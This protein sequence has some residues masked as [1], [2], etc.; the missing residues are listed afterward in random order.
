MTVLTRQG[1]GTRGNR[2]VPPC[3]ATYLRYGAAGEILA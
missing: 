3:V 2:T 1:R